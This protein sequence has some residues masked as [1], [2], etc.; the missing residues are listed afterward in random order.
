MF[1]MIC[2]IGALA[3]RER[4]GE[5]LVGFSNNVPPRSPCSTPDEHRKSLSRNVPDYVSN[6]RVVEC[7]VSVN[8]VNTEL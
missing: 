1:M 3:L 8:N 6:M 4:A 5:R 2:C 7:N